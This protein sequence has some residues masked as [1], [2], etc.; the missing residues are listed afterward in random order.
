[1][2]TAF[3]LHKLSPASG[4]TP[5]THQVH[6]RGQVNLKRKGMRALELPVSREE[7]IVS[8]NFAT[9]PIQ[10]SGSGLENEDRLPDTIYEMKKGRF[11][12]FL[13]EVFPEKLLIYHAGTGRILFLAV[14][15]L[16][17]IAVSVLFL[18]VLAPSFYSDDKPWYQTASRKF[19][20][21]VLRPLI[22]PRIS[23]KALH[24]L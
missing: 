13:T 21:F 8:R 16:T 11:A 22:T 6:L 10:T 18:G 23:H 19:L 24:H 20:S 3:R 4:G 17:T 14:L 2:V 1:M 9:I 15:K 7:N 12:N 5:T